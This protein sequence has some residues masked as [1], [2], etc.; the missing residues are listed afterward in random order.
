M[1]LEHVKDVAL[2]RKVADQNALAY[3]NGFRPNVLV[4][5]RIFEDGADVDAAFVRKSALADERLLSARAEIGHIGN[6]PRQCGQVSQLFCADNVMAHL[7][8]QVGDN[9]AE[10]G[11]AAAF[12]ISVDAAL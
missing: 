6:G 11:V 2:S 7:Q 3:T 1:L 12:A 10:I 9:R 8:L 5:G 4:G